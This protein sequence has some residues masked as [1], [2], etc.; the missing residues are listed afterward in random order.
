MRSMV[1]GDD[2]ATKKIE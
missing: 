2:F 1:G